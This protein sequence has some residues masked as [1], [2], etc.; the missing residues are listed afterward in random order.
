MPSAPLLQQVNNFGY[1]A[2]F[3]G[4][5]ELGVD[6]GGFTGTAFINYLNPRKISRDFLP[7]TVSDKY[8]RIGSYTTVDVTLRYAFKDNV[9]FLG[10]GWAVSMSVLNLLDEKPPLVVNAGGSSP[11]RFDPSYSSSLGRFVS[12][13]VSKK[14]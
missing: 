10:E 11:I 3:S 6:S 5:L 2:R 4:R 12:F 1:P 9:S 14:F 7:S 13:Q 8:L